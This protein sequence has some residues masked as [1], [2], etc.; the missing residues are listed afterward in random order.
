MSVRVGLG[1]RWGVSV[2]SRVGVGVSIGA[3]FG[4]SWKGFGLGVELGLV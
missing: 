1:L 3:G 2:G 4:V